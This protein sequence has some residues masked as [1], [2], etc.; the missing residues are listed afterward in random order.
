MSNLEE[1]FNCLRVQLSIA[2]SEYNS[3]KAGKQSSAPR[4]RKSLMALKTGSHAMRAGTTSF[5]RVLPTKTR[6]KA[7]E[8][9]PL[10]PIVET[11]VEPGA[12]EVPKKPTKSRKKTVNPES[13]D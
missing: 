13:E 11:E 10:E 12:I 6:K 5:V 3:L 1:Q 9:L 4:L 7:C 2:E 8:D